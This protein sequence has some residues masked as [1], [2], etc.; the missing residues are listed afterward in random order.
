[1]TVLKLDID[2]KPPDKWIKEW[3]KTRKIILN[4]Y[5]IKILRM[6]SYETEK[7]IHY[8]I[9][10]DRDLSAEETNMMQFLLG[11]DHTRVKINQ[12]RL[13]RGIEHW[14]KLFDRKIWRKEQETITCWYCGNIIPLI[15][16]KDS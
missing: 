15:V 16:N 3:E 2:L 5:N 6:A 11:D 8:F 10:I 7:G 13:E 12:W 14:N 1:M 9:E 4:S